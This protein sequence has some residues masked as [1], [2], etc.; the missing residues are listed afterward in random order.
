MPA[1]NNGLEKEVTYMLHNYKYGLLELRHYARA[2]GRVPF[3]EWLAELDRSIAERVRTCVKRMESGNFGDSKSV[4]N[5]VFE[6]RL[7]FGAGY[8]VY[9][10]RDGQTLVILLCGGDKGS[11]QA[12]MRRAQEYA[13]DY[14]RQK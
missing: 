6:L 11:Q 9:Y 8:R 5:G 7:H 4:P 14:W 12:D 2:D 1:N 13:E 10:L 3:A